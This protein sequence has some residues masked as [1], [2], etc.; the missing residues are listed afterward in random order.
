MNIAEI[1]LNYLTLKVLLL[2]K[3]IDLLQVTDKL[4][5]IMLY[6]VI[7]NR[8]INTI[9]IKFVVQRKFPSNCSKVFFMFKGRD[10]LMHEA[11]VCVPSYG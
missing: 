10:V 8:R 7:E 11:I 5:R 1:L 9:R 2:E 3:T 6:R 4:Y